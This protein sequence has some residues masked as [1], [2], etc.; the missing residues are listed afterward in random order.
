MRAAYY[1]R[2][3]N[4]GDILC[5]GKVP[6]PEPDPGDVRVRVRVSAINP[7]DTKSRQG[8]GGDTA[9]RFPRIVPHNDGAGVI[10]EVGPGVSAARIG[11]R[12]WLFEAQ[13]DG[14][15]FGTAAE[16]VVVPAGNAIALP[17]NASFDDGASLGVP[18]MTAHHL[19]FSDGAIHGQTILIQGGA[20]SVGHLATQLARW[21]GARVIA[22]V[23]SDEQAAVARDCG[24]HHVINYKTQDVVAEVRRF[25][26]AENASTVS[27][28]WLS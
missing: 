27:S 4:P 21:A 17:N 18:G 23:G 13:R 28:R 26:R 22:T 1:E 2:K 15:A 16:F 7:S 5:V 20:G 25:G 19:L 8:W 14:R 6:T 12:V 9:M 3:G 10:D 24:A 11:E